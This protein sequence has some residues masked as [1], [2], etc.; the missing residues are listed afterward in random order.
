[1]QIFRGKKTEN[2]QEND[3]GGSAGFGNPSLAE[4]PLKN[5]QN[6]NKKTEKNVFGLI[7]PYSRPSVWRLY[8]F[9]LSNFLLP[10]PPPP[11]TAFVQLTVPICDDGQLMF[12]ASGTPSVPWLST[13]AILLA[14]PV[15]DDGQLMSGAS[16]ARPCHG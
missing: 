9:P 14:V 2:R 5:Q 7:V 11:P 6:P 13:N 8:D 15:G 12:G 10:P 16:G 4:N 3:F 1:M